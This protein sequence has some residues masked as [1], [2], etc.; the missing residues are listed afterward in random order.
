MKT[1]KKIVVTEVASIFSKTSTACN[2]VRDPIDIVLDTIREICDACTSSEMKLNQ[3]C[4]YML[5]FL[6]NDIALLI[7]E[8]HVYMHC[9]LPLLPQ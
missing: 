5:N 8:L 7:F 6:Y 3:V 9:N 4:C 1:A 2:P